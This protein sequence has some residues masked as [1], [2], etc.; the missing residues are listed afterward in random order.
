MATPEEIQKLLK[1]LDR[2]Y[3]DLGT[4]NPFANFD[5]SKVSD[6]SSAVQIL[7]SGLRDAKRELDDINGDLNETIIGFKKTVDEI[8]NTNSGLSLA[9]KT[10]SGLSDLT[11]KLKSDQAGINELSGKE[12]KN[13]QS[14]AKEKR[15]DLKVSKDL[16]TSRIA[17]LKEL[18]KKEPLNAK[19]K[20]ELTES[21]SASKAVKN[22]LREQDTLSTLINGKLNQRIAQETRIEKLLGLGG[23]TVAGT[24]AALDKLGFGGLANALG[25]DEVQEKMR[26]VA[27]EIEKSEGYTG[28]FSD[29]MKVLK[30]GISEAGIQ[31]KQSLK[32]P[33][34]I[35]T[36]LIKEMISALQG[37]DKATGE[38]AKSFGT[39]YSEAASLR[40]ELN[41]VANLS[42]DVNV[43]TAALQKSLVAINKEFGTAS[44]LN[45]ELLKD[46]TQLT[47]VAG[48]TE[49]AALGLSRITL[50]TGTDLSDN[51]SEI[52]GQ[53]VA[54]N[55]ANG[56]ALNEKEIVEGVAKASAATTL[57]LGM[58]PKELAKAVAQS[59]ALGVS[60]DQVESISQSLLNFESSISAELEAELL[61]GKNLNLEKARLAALNGDLATVA[62]EIAKQT[63]SAADFTKMN[64]IQQEAL[65]KS[66]GMTR[67]DLAKSLI[68]REALAAAGLKEGTAVD[69][70]NKLKK[71]GLSD[72]QIAKKLG[73][74]KLAAQLKSQS[75]QERF[76]A[77]IEKLREIF[78]S[79]AGPILQI[80]SPFL[81]LVTKILPLIN[82]VLTPITF[83][84]QL[85]GKSIGFI[86]D[87][88]GKFVDL[89]KQSLDV[90]TV[91]GTVL[92]F[93]YRQQIIT[94]ALKTKDFIVDKASLLLG[95]ES[96]V[97]ETAKQAKAA[98]TSAFENRN[99]F[100]ALGI[101][102]VK[103]GSAVAGIPF[104]GPLLAAAAAAG[105]YA[106]G[107][108][109][110]ADDM[111]S[112]SGYGK[113]TLMAPEGTI[114]LNDKDTVIAGT[115]LGG[116]DKNQ[117]ANSSSP[118]IN[119]SPLVERMSAVENLLS[120]ILSKEGTVFLDGNKV[121]TAMAMSTYKTQ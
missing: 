71:E 75:V 13:I 115:N 15:E 47:T 84:F 23:A 25:L 91:F 77:S 46:F 24:K 114:Q 49:E 82:V 37:A 52:L 102:A 22:E 17:E 36:L 6:A 10:F 74:D 62:E 67:E 104:V 48:Y 119:L 26:K 57:S 56:L 4:K 19:Q 98:I 80:V 38:L 9:N 111:V 121:G 106:L 89:L 103:A 11:R 41:T 53:A 51:T 79:L 1:D 45:G 107:K 59:K 8:K 21:I 101:L 65:A 2:V 31:F 99:F 32:D 108:S 110:F 69:A 78:I 63:G 88:M 86:V 16:L 34:A 64:V 93:I 117:S 72:D 3:K 90:A 92:A 35:A 42:G 66:V 29:K 44:K 109:Y 58:Q 100:K 94:S 116:G 33:A 18:E 87:G 55:A 28:G 14:Q 83:T 73:D 50:A 112:S 96:L 81:D 76:N 118:S 5:A 12:L 105:A 20:K 61:T 40:N 27:D 39:S 43:N 68:E 54:F 70:Y 60:L 95:K 30:A 7:N 120:Q 113:R 97:V 85:I